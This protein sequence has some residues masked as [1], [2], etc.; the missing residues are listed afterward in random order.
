VNEPT[1]ERSTSEPGSKSKARAGI[2][3]AVVTALT[4]N[5]RSAAEAEFSAIVSRLA[6]ARV[7]VG[8]YWVA[9]GAGRGTSIIVF[10]SQE[11]SA[12]LADFAQGTPYASVT[13]EAIEV[14]EVLARA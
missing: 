8:G 13:P 3:Y 1:D 11:A 12:A 5:D 9:L 4:F 2:A 10:D 7:F 14:G 6:R